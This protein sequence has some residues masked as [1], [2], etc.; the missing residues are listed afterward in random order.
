VRKSRENPLEKN[1]SIVVSFVCF[2]ASSARKTYVFQ[3][4]HPK[5]VRFSASSARKTYV[6]QPF[7]PEKR[8]FFRCHREKNVC[9]SAASARKM[10]VFPPLPPEK[11]AFFSHF[12]PKNVCF[13]ATSAQNMYDAGGQEQKQPKWLM[14][15]VSF[16]TINTA[17]W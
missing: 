1:L 6:F 8:M 16:S 2:S 10:Y 4:L 14:A 3:P 7:L 15:T 17:L 11:R 13:S 5:K 9:F 12:H